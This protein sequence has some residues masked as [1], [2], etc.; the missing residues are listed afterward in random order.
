MSTPASNPSEYYRRT[1]TVPILDHLPAEL[2][3]RFT[4]HQKTAYKVT[5]WCH[6]FWEK[7]IFKLCPLYAV[8]LP[9]LSSL[10]AELENWHTKWESE[11]K[12][13]GFNALP[14]TLSSTLPRISCFYPN[15]K[16]LLTVLCTLPV[17]SCPA[18]RSFS[19][20]KRVNTPLRP[21]MT[22]ERLSS[23][24]LLHIHHDIPVVIEEVIDEFSRRYPR[25][26]QLSE[27]PSS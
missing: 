2:D 9:D 25:R 23:L 15:I 26:L 4:S 17:T 6:Q 5:I 18:E 22:N 24:T 8:D 14:S 21:N 19:G 1:I 10:N 11:E 16:A 7:R 3:R 13:Y 12:E 27:V 20:L